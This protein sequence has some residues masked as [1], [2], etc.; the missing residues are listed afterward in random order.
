MLNFGSAQVGG[1]GGTQYWEE[2]AQPFFN[3]DILLENNNFNGVVAKANDTPINIETSIFAYRESSSDWVSSGMYTADSGNLNTL[4]ISSYS[5][6][7]DLGEFDSL[8]I[9]TIQSGTYLG[10]NYEN[11]FI[12][13][14][15]YIAYYYSD[16]TRSLAMAAVISNDI[17]S[18]EMGWSVQSNNISGYVFGIDEVG[19]ICTNQVD[20][21]HTHTTP[22]GSIP[23]HDT[24]GVYQGKIL[25][26]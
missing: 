15:T 23:I 20:P 7:L 19:K 21:T 3:G 4:V 14:D 17:N 6:I 22:I 16:Q 26:Y 8:T 18:G 25:L 10:N 1:G 9:G 11:H 2:V 24:S 5:T 13:T 12:S